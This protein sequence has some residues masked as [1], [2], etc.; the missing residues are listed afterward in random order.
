M[1]DLEKPIC[2]F[3]KSLAAF[4]IY[5][6]SPCYQVEPLLPVTTISSVARYMQVGTVYQ[7]HD[8]NRD[9]SLE[10]KYRPQEYR[11]CRTEQL[12]GIHSTVSLIFQQGFRRV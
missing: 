4:K 12:L 3:T 2:I 11:A 5:G 6:F 10:D 1:N 7:D 9:S 8:P